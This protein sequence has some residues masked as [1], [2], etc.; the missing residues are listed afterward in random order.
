MSEIMTERFSDP[1]IREEVSEKLK[2]Y[3]RDNPGAREE[4]SKRVR[5][6]Y[7]EHPEARLR[8]SESQKQRWSDPEYREHLTKSRREYWEDSGNRVRMS[9]IKKQ[10]YIDHPEAAVEHGRKVRELYENNPSM[11]VEASERSRRVHE[12]NPDLRY[13][14][15]RMVQNTDTGEVFRS[16]RDAARSVGVD[17]G[18]NISKCLQ[19]KRRSAYGF[20]WEYA[21]T[22]SHNMIGQ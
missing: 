21:G 1:R 11:R 9:E 3:Y 19:G 13:S 20:H 15:A 4:N 10:Y 22:E 6:Y 17:T 5:R 12:E 2:A 16:V 14:R 7:E 18:T 8:M